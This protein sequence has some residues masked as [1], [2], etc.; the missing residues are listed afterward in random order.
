MR[1]KGKALKWLYSKPEF[2]EI[3][4]EAL[5]CELKNMFNYRPSRMKLRKDFE[6]REWKKGE[7]F[8]DYMHEK[9]ILGNRIPIDED[10]IAEYIIDGISDRMLR[11]QA[12]VSGLKTKAAL[13]EAFERV[14][15]RDKKYH[16]TK[17]SEEKARVDKG[18]KASRK[19]R[20][21]ERRT[22]LTAA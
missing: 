13:L 4:V 9:V 5:L 18:E 6:E 19:H 12:H 3:S 7:T 20:R 10:E 11:D 22:T 14:T 1:L 15:L 8:S 17:F 21:A 2:L 16:P